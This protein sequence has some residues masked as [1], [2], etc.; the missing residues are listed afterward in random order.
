MSP[1]HTIRVL[2][3]DDDEDEHVLLRSLIAK[4]EAVQVDLAWTSSFDDALTSMCRREYDAYL[5]DYQLG[6]RTG[7]ELLEMSIAAGCDDPVILLTGHKDPALDAAALHAGAVDFVNKQEMSAP[8]LERSIRYAVARATGAR[9]A[10]A[11]REQK[12]IA[13]VRERL[14]GIVGHDLRNPLASISTAGHVLALETEFPVEQ[15]QHIGR[16]ILASAERMARMINEVL[17]FTRA[18]LGAGIP[19]APRDVDAF[20]LAQS[21]VDEVR[22]ANPDRTVHLA[23]SGEGQVQWDPERIAQVLSN[24]LGNALH[25]GDPRQPIS[26]ALIGDESGMTLSVHN[27]GPLI[28]PDRAASLF[29]PFRRG[30]GG[31]GRTS[32]GL[33]L[34]LYIVKEIVHGHKGAIAVDSTQQRGTTFQ[35]ILLRNPLSIPAAPVV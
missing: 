27:H 30:D 32:D 21:V 23:T 14:I 2:L 34:G 1:E 24:L 29:D 4:A 19:I 28:P 25:H 22:V 16:T 9:L 17:D 15:R 13:Q 18:R 31:A 26:V 35:V 5:V 11:L 20:A 7:L 3:V 12:E 6:A 10:T 8:L 33:G